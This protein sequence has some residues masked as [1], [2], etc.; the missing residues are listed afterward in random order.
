MRALPGEVFFREQIDVCSSSR[1]ISEHV[2]SIMLLTK[3][4]TT[5]I[6]SSS[7]AW[8]PAVSVSWVKFARKRAAI[9]DLMYYDSQ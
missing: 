3:L 8:S 4:S 5:S 1:L 9:H 6:T 7:P 2:G